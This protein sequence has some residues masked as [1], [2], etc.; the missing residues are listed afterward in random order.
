LFPSGVGIG[1]LIAVFVRDA[2]LIPSG[3]ELRIAGY[4][5][6]EFAN[7]GVPFLSLHGKQAFVISFARTGRRFQTSGADGGGGCTRNG[8]KDDGADIGVIEGA[9]EGHADMIGAITSEQGLQLTV[10]EGAGDG[11]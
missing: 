11:H 5:G 1:R 4:G 8:V 6:R 7:G 3:G 10:A 9:F 2:E